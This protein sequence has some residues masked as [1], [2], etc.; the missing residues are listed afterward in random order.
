LIC[1]DLPKINIETLRI[2]GLVSEI[3]EPD[4]NFTESELT[5]YFKQQGLDINSQTIREIYK[6]IAGWAF[7][8]NLVARSLKKVP[9]Y[10]GFVKTTLK[11][12]VFELMESENWVSLSDNLKHFLL[13]LSLIE[14]LSAEL[15][16]ILADGDADLLLEFKQQSAYIR[17]DSFGGAYLIHHMY[18]AFLKS[19]QYTLTDKEKQETYRAAADWCNR[20]NFKMD[21]LR[22]YEKIRDYGS[23]VLIFRDF[24][25]Y[26]TYDTALY[27]AAIF[28]RTPDEIYN[29]VS[30]FAAMRLYNLLCLGRWQEFF[31]LAENYEKR[32]LALPENDTFRNHTLGGIYYVWG[33]VRQLTSTF[34]GNCDFDL[35]YEKMANHMLISP[36][37]LANMLTLPVGAW[38]SAVGSSDKG[39]PQKYIEAMSRT[40][41]HVSP[42]FSGIKG[43]SD[44]ITGELLFY[45]NDIR[46]AQTIFLEEIEHARENRQFDVLQRSLFYIL[47]IAVAQG[48]REKA[49]QTLKS[50]EA[51][52]DEND[53]LRG[54]ITYDITLGWYYCMVRQFDMVSDWI[55]AEFSPYGHACFIENFSNQIRARYYYLKRIYPPLL[56]YISEMKKRE[57][58]LYGRVEML[59]MEACIYYQ[60][61]DKS[62]AL[63]ALKTAYETASPNNIIMPFIE[64]GK[65]MRTLTM[66]ALN[67]PHTDIPRGWLEIIKNKATSY[68]KNQSMFINEYKLCESAVNKMLSS[69]EQ[70][71]LSD[72]YH[73][74][75]QAEIARKHSLSINTVKMVT[76]SIYEKLHVHKISD[77][78]RVAAEQ[79]LV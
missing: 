68:A 77:L 50:L 20:N 51:L 11:P 78:I 35:Y 69:R 59:A 65:D 24:L 39:A 57:S 5:V 16:D 41:R 46:A 71:V 70:D 26:T 55:K 63:S 45:Q 18:L 58:V 66:A 49:E 56:N 38:F 73:G 10:L 64:F 3:N 61:K 21:A 14:H 28:E 29:S 37:E 15:I 54:N 52:L 43:A 76:K 60:M 23:I 2:K 47:R 4:L 6:D 44:I 1:R 33:C 67:E 34:D 42:C 22:Y 75:S 79:R 19:K 36:A 7:T 13:R 25:E 17:F 40:E 53:Y 31:T 62:S 12:N 74:F 27:T 30:F 48:N 72:L 9:K 32:F 8:V